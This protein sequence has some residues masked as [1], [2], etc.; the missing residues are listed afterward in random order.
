MGSVGN[1]GRYS[2]LST[3]GIHILDIKGLTF[4]TITLAEDVFC[5]LSKLQIIYHYYNADHLIVNL[6]LSAY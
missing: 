1:H 4:Q 2:Q 5:F 3:L 6:R